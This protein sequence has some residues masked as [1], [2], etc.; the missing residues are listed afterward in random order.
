[1]NSALAHDWVWMTQECTAAAVWIPPGQSE[2]SEA[3]ER[4]LGPL[5]DE[6]APDRAELLF[7]LF[8]LFE[9]SHPHD[10]PHYYLS[11]LGTDTN[12]LGRGIGLGLLAH[13]LELIDRQHAPAFLE[14]SNPGNVA[15]YQRHGFEPIGGFDAPAGGPHVTAMWRPAA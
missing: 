8:E 11:L 7:E 3:E 5:I 4:L 10:Q 6:L 9:D 2:L 13:N 12:H 14:A 1:M 15:L